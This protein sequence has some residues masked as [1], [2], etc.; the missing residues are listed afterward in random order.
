MTFETFLLIVTVVYVLQGLVFLAGLRRLRDSDTGVQ[1]FVSVVIAARNEA[2]NLDACLRSVLTQTYPADKYEVILADDGSTDDTL[3]IARRFS[4]GDSRLHC[5][6]VTEHSSMRGKSNALAQAIDVARGEVVL[7][8]DADCVVPPTWVEHTAKRYAPG[9]GLVGGVTLHRATSAFE[10]IQCLDWAFLLGTAASTAGLGYPL[11][12]IGNNLSFR[13]R[14]YDEVGGY[15]ALKF[16]VTEDYTIVQAIV[17]SGRWKYSYPI[18]PR[19][20]VETRPCPDLKT[21]VRQKQRW[22]K[23]GLDMRLGGL[24]IMVIGFAMHLSPFVMLY[25]GGV[26]AAASA[27]MAKFVVDYAFLYSVLQRL[28]RTDELKY[29]YWFEVYF[30]LYVLALPFLVF[31]GGRVHWKGR[32]F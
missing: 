19:V 1:S 15:R 24:L 9:V 12:S 27:L 14:A 30:I 17:R 3:G 23:G 16:S 2:D 8:T 31:F 25:W 20:L 4:A 18:D 5:V 32:T 26:V 28:G 13:R 10:G 22:G 6:S 7:I 11:S 29:F 21:L